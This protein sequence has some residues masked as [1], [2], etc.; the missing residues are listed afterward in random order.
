MK[1]IL[2][3]GDSNTFGFDTKT[4]IKDTS[5][6]AR[7]TKD[8]R[9]T[10][11]LQNI[12]GKEYYIIEEGLCGRTTVSNDPLHSHLAGID[13][14]SPLLKTH[15]PLDLLIIMLG[16]NDVKERF[17]LSPENISLGLLRLIKEAKNCEFAWRTKP[18]ILIMT[19][20]AI[21]KRYEESFVGATMGKNCA[22][23]SSELANFYKDIASKENC[24]YLDLNK[25]KGMKMNDIDFMHLDEESHKI[26]GNTLAELVKTLV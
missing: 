20:L 13:M 8:K 11:L 12:L 3:F 23:K 18:N 15:Y 16:T 17:C 22:I 1:N 9:Y 2:C 26:L 24:A 10:G 5:I 7:F 25:I 19:P 6:N 4:Y 14:L 21:D